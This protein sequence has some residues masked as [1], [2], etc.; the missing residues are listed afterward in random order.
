MGGALGLYTSNHVV[1]NFPVLWPRLGSALGST[2]AGG[3]V[4]RDDRPA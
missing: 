2:I 1:P 3:P 4:R